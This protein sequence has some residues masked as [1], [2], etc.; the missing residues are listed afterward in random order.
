MFEKIFFSDLCCFV[1][2]KI[3]RVNCGNHNK[4]ENLFKNKS[5]IGLG[6][7]QDRRK[8]VLYDLGFAKILMKK[9]YFYHMTSV[10]VDPRQKRNPM[11]RFI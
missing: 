8:K 5:G 7:Y 11:A 3:C 1:K 4:T 10:L 2:K 6:S 9:K